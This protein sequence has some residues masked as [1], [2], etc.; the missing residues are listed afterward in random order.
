MSKFHLFSQFFSMTQDL[1]NDALKI[2]LLK[3]LSCSTL[4]R[5][6]L[7]KSEGT[8]PDEFFPFFMLSHAV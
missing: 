1:V 4:F 5:G 8:E 3:L 7:T 6:F 2:E